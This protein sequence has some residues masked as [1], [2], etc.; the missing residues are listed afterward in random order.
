MSTTTKASPP[1]PSTKQ[2]G[3]GAVSPHPVLGQRNGEFQAYGTI[4]RL[5]IGL[6][7]KV[8]AASVAALN[9]VLADTITLRDMYKKHHWQVSGHTFY[10]LH[11]LFDKHADEQEK[12][13]DL[14]A[15][16]IQLLGGVSIAMAHDV[17]ETTRVPRP[18]RGREEV[19]VQLCR[20]LE[21]HEII[22]RQSREEAHKAADSGDDG[23]ND[24][25][26]SDVIRTNELQV[27][28]VSEHLVE[29]PVVRAK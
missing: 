29:G 17:A 4:V 22:L 27:W 25:L 26:V 6:D 8:C 19:P 3:D 20:L 28:F 5:P 18:P 16:R 10:Q 21:A 24:L 7:E 11:L 1:A 12:L 23:T 13:I 14:I 9:Q 2:A 15:E